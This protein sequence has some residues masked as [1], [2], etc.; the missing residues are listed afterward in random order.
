[1]DFILPCASKISTHALTWSATTD[2]DF[3]FIA[4]EIST[5]ALT[6]SATRPANRRNVHGRF[7]LTHSRGVRPSL[8][9]GGFFMSKISTHALTWSATSAGGVGGFPPRFQLTHSRGVR[10]VSDA[11]RDVFAP[12]QLTHSRG[13]RHA[14][15]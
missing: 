12:F 5:H 15:D 2:L 9:Q 4:Q 13:V 1:M 10:P 11:D 3:V 6:W 14:H 8:L 7:Q